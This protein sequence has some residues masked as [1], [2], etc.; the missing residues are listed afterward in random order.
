MGLEQKLAGSSC[1]VSPQARSLGQV[2]AVVCSRVAL[3]PCTSALCWGFPSSPCSTQP[4]LT[5]PRDLELHLEVLQTLLMT[6]HPTLSHIL[7]HSTPAPPCSGTF[8]P[9]VPSLSTPWETE[10]WGHEAG[11]PGYHLRERRWPPRRTICSATFG[12]SAGAAVFL[13]HVSSLPPAARSCLSVF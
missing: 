11:S 10:G 5:T 7:Q 6:L 13:G 1:L 12:D 9:N 8:L 4:G 2:G 3:S